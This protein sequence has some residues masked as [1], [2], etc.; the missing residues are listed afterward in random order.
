M[1]HSLPG[2]GEDPNPENRTDND[3]FLD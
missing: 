3:R 2:P 1:P